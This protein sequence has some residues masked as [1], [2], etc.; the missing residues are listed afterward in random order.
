[1]TSTQPTNIAIQAPTVDVSGKVVYKSG[2]W[3]SRYPARK[4]TADIIVTDTTGAT[5]FEGSGETDDNGKFR[6]KSSFIAFAFSQITLQ[7][8]EDFT[9]QDFDLTLYPGLIGPNQGP[10]DVGEIV[11]PFEP[12][13]SELAWVNSSAFKD[14]QN[15]A[16]A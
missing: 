9:G 11:F 8:H 7:I 15:F 13:H 6:A 2:P 1:M 14:T 4:A 16:K 3:G 5:S 12:E 10:Q